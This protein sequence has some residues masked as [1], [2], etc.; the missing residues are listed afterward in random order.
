M[1]DNVLSKD[2]DYI[3]EKTF[4]VW[5]ELRGQSLFITG[6]TGFFGCWLLESFIWVNKKL[7][8]NAR[9]MVLTRHIDSFTRKYPHLAKSSD[10]TFLE[11]DVRSFTFPTETF[12]HIIHAATD[13]SVELNNTN[14][15]LMID[16]IIE[17]TKHT[18]EFARHNGSKGFLFIGSGAVYGKQPTTLS[19]LP[20]HYPCQPDIRDPRSAYAVAKVAAEHLCYIYA[21]QYGINVKIARCFAFVGPYLPLNIHYAVGNFI[22]DG[23]KGGP[24]SVKGDGTTFRSYLYAADLCIWLWT[25]LY[26]GKVAYPYNVGSDEAICIADL[27]NIISKNFDPIPLIEIREA[28]PHNA[29]PERYIPDIRRAREELK[30][31]PRIS[32]KDAIQSTIQ[33]YSSSKVVA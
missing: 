17:G 28:P 7:N 5:E 30:L 23:L 9:A 32:L 29:L 11:G 31:I 20:E 13:A 12:S 10:I 26:Q 15:V 2:L 24:I 8:L 27:A 1:L 33:W 3:L 6:G 4:H 18:L 25:I 16:T 14:P 21:K 19:H 22:R